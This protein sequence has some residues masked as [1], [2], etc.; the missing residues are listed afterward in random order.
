[1]KTGTSIEWKIKR[2]VAYAVMEME[3]KE[4]YQR[5]N[6]RVLSPIRDVGRRIRVCRARMMMMTYSSEDETDTDKSRTIDAAEDR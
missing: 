2:Q 1:M 6:I 4:L 5:V 3:L